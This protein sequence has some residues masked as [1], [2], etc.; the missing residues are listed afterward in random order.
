MK[1]YQAASL[2]LSGNRSSRSFASGAV[3]LLHIGLVIAITQ[4]LDVR[5]PFLA[6]NTSTTRVIDPPPATPPKPLVWQPVP[7]TRPI[8]SDPTAPPLP[9]IDNGGNTITEIAAQLPDTTPR[10]AAKPAVSLPRT[11]PRHPLS[12]PPYPA[13]AR[14]AG[15]EGTVELSLYVLVSGR[16]GEAKVARSSGSNE[17][18]E[19]AMRE[20]LRAWRLIPQRVDGVTVA[21]WHNIAVTFQ[22]RNN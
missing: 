6:P 22:L 12:Q 14:R 3:V 10:T 11:D 21:A 9:P 2:T 7:T 4:G 13:S 8:P 5:V 16:I 17:L 19:A 15:T 1:N 18:D 20:A